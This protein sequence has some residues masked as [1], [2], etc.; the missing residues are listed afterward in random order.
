MSTTTTVPE[1]L[2]LEFPEGS[3]EE[4]V[5]I[6]EFA[7]SLMG[8]DPTAANARRKIAGGESTLLL[9]EVYRVLDAFELFASV[10]GASQTII[11]LAEQIIGVVEPLLDAGRAD[12]LNEVTKRQFDAARAESEE[13]R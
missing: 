6:I 5:G 2:T 1:T 13:A 12:E 4:V 11:N 3:R 8:P 9:A 10:F 7:A